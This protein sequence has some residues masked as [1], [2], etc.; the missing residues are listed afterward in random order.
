MS[1]DL[2]QTAFNVVNQMHAMIAYW[3]SD[4]RCTFSNLAYQQW[5]DKTLDEMMGITLQEL[6]GP[7]LYELNR[8]HILGVLRGE[9]QIFKRSLVQRSGE[10]RHF[11][12]TYTPD[13]AGEGVRGFS[14]HVTE[15]PA[16]PPLLEWLPICANCKDIQT[17]SGE[18][19]PIEAY[20]S[21]HS[22]ISF[23]HSLCPQCMP[24][25]F[26]DSDAVVKPS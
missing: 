17:A 26:P 15:L 6:L 25:Y 23:T 12:A 21:Q 11:L 2:S 20:F 4:E 22:K 1:L 24:R 14:V 3:T 8:P 19:H 16:Q 10:S 9:K 7:E 13:L 18:W 5:F